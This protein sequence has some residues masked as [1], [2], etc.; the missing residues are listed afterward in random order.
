MIDYLVKWNILLLI[1]FSSWNFGGGVIT[2]FRYTCI[3]MCVCVCHSPLGPQMERASIIYCTAIVGWIWYSRLL[4]DMNEH[5]YHSVGVLYQHTTEC[6]E[7]NI[8]WTLRRFWFD[9][10]KK[11]IVT[12]KKLT[13]Y[14]KRYLLQTTN[15]IYSDN[16]RYLLQTTNAI[17][18]RQQTLST[19]TTNAIYYRQQTLSTSDNKRY[20]LRQQ[21]L[22]T[23]TTNA[24][25]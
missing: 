3:F 25:Y 24:I 11:L 13:P 8:K 1:S 19:Q 6:E 7:N 10:K 5:S 17:Y 12:K 23:Q 9:T 22:S 15:A 16:K 21:T 14:N 18:F 4:E 2:S 20:L